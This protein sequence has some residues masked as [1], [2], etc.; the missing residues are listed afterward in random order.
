MNLNQLTRFPEDKV[1]SLVGLTHA[2]LAE[3]FLVALPEI[4]RRRQQQQTDKPNRRRQVGGGRTRL[5]KP[6]Q[7]ILLTLI[8][9]RHNVAFSVVG[10]MMGVSA[11]VAENTFHEIV[12]VL[13]D[14]CPANR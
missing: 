5:L 11:D 12:A 14:V 10:Q 1:R 6:Y 4:Q 2:A 3:L 9:L 8:Y 13:R 7:E